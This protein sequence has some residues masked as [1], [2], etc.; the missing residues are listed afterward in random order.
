MTLYKTTEHVVPFTSPQN[1]EMLHRVPLEVSIFRVS[2]DPKS[3]P[4]PLLTFLLLEDEEMGRDNFGISL[5]I[6]QV[7]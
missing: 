4:F 7:R 3:R 5:V 2:Q 6:L 1:I